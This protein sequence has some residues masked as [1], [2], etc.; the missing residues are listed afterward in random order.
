MIAKKGSGTAPELDSLESADNAF[1]EPEN[2]FPRIRGKAAFKAFSQL[3][4]TFGFFVAVHADDTCSLT[5]VLTAWEAA[6][7]FVHNPERLPTG[8][9]R[10]GFLPLRAS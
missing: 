3:A 1:R 4:Q 2:D 10:I 8:E 7:I 9:K 6:V 5:A